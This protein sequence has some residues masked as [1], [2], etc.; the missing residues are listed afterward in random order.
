[1]KYFAFDLYGTL[2]RIKTDESSPAFRAKVSARFNKL[3]GKEINF[4]EEYSRI[5]GEADPEAEPD[6]IVAVRAIAKDGGAELSERAARAFALRFRRDSTVRIGVYKGVRKT[7][8][9][10]RKAGAKVFLLSNAQSSF[11]L[12]EIK[13]CRLYRYFD[14]IE[15]SSD[16]GKKKPSL[17]FFNHLADKYSIDLNQAVYTGNDCA[18]DIIPAKSL[19][20]KAVYVR[21]DISPDEDDFAAVSKIA[22]FASDGDFSRAGKYLLSLAE[23]D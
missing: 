15:L 20:M 1:M 8:K 18:C 21:S 4:W 23:S 2:I 3:C 17:K 6:F 16:F 11:T 7:L 5:F 19:G 13:R 12:P 22:D 9:S 10:L 14:G